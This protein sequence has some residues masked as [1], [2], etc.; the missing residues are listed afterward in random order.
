MLTKARKYFIAVSVILASLIALL[1]FFRL[2]AYGQF[3]GSQ[4]AECPAGYIY[5]VGQQICKPDCNEGEV[6]K[7]GKCASICLAGFI[8]SPEYERCVPA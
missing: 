4:K 5:D 1:Y 3:A 7:E 6:L 2:G 8:Y